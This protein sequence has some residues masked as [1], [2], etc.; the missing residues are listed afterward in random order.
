MQTRDQYRVS[1]ERAQ[2][3][4]RAR[5]RRR[6]TETRRSH[7][8]PRDLWRASSGMLAAVEQQQRSLLGIDLTIPSGFDPNI[9]EW[10]D[11]T[12][13]I[14]LDGSSN[15]EEWVGR[16]SGAVL[17]QTT[18]GNRPSISSADAEFNGADVISMLGSG[19]EQLVQTSAPFT[20][21]QPYA[22]IMVVTGTSVTPFDA[23]IDTDNNTPL[24][25]SSAGS[26]DLRST[27]PIP[28]SSE[29]G[30]IGPAVIYMSLD[31]ASSWGTIN[32]TLA[33]HNVANAGAVGISRPL[34]INGLDGG[35]NQIAG[36]L[37]IRHI[38]VT[39]PGAESDYAAWLNSDQ[40]AEIADTYLPPQTDLIAWHDVPRALSV[41][42]GGG[43]DDQ[44]CTAWANI[45]SGGVDLTA[46]SSRPEYDAAGGPSSTPTIEFGTQARSAVGRMQWASEL[47]ASAGPLT[48]FIVCDP[49]STSGDQRILA[50]PS[51]SLRIYSALSG[52]VQVYTGSGLASFGA[53]TTGPQVLTMRGASA[54]LEM[55]RGRTSL[56]TSGIYAEPTL[57]AGTFLGANRF[58]S[59]NYFDG[60][61]A[62]VYLVRASLS[63]GE[64]TAF[65]DAIAGKYPDYIT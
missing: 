65:W 26:W 22:V 45:I 17:G 60:D 21:A 27:T 25:Y 52:N 47:D 19:A 1:Q 55:Y 37:K 15:V 41:V 18:P 59:G 61:I 36:T 53:A 40:G 42:G 51:G 46:A 14:S 23:L 48:A 8:N 57:P 12:E 35:T 64:L 7:N 58:G 6:R 20:V 2:R 44:D 16:I 38:I 63:A 56:G 31:G 39:R 34:V 5:E 3:E 4:L 30:L 43:A 24:L 62:A 13:G 50:A 9:I 33:P 49:K 11:S 10:W 54:D 28:I 29:L 32:G